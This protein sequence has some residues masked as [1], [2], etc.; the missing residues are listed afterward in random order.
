MRNLMVLI[1][2]L[3]GAA[4]G[5][6]KLHEGANENGAEASYGLGAHYLNGSYM[7]NR[8]SSIEVPPGFWVNL[9]D[10]HPQ[11]EHQAGERNQAVAERQ[12]HARRH[13]QN[14]QRQRHQHQRHQ[15][16]LPLFRAAGE[17]GQGEAERAK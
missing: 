11:Q 5:Q 13:R 10:Q 14:Q 2:V 1:L 9:C 8:A 7:D 16:V 3:A 17:H 12:F 15:V 6:V 4:F